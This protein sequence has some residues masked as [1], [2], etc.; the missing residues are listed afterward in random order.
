MKIRGELLISAALGA[1]VLTMALCVVFFLTIRR[2]PRSTLSPYTTLFRSPRGPAPSGGAWQ[3][4][5]VPP[6]G[7]ADGP[8]SG[9]Q[10]SL[11]ATNAAP[12]GFPAGLRVWV[13]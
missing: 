4:P 10:A 8:S 5:A 3:A 6:G 13:T 9:P 7:S 2:P 12:R 11:R 1:L